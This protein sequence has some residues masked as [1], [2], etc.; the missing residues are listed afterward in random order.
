MKKIIG[1]TFAFV[2]VT[3]GLI[4]IDWH[5]LGKENAYVQVGDVTN[6]EE[7]TLDSGEVVRRYVYETEA[8]TNDGEARDVTF[9]AA[10][11]LRQGAF[12][13]LYMKDEAVTSYDEVEV[14]D[15]PEAAREK[16]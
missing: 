13:M 15:V 10:K 5:R 3:V 11:E 14:S 1:F 4:N 16:L 12:L 9:T 2:L 8:Y 6:V 7:T